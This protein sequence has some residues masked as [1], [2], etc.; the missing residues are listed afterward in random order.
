MRRRHYESLT[1][2][3]LQDFVF[4]ACEG[5][6]DTHG[7][8]HMQDVADISLEIFRKLGSPADIFIPVLL[9]SWLHDVADHKY[10]KKGKLKQ[11]V[12]VF[13]EKIVGEDVSLIM[14]TIDCISFS[15]ENAA[16]KSGNPLDFNKILG[17]KYALVRDIVSDADKTQAIGVEGINRCIKFTRHTYF[18]KNG[19]EIPLDELKENVKKHAEEKLLRLKDEFFRTEPGKEMTLELHEEMVKILSGL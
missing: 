10:D 14:I 2:K 6:D 3:A 7:F 1:E 8:T 11:K 17:K 15:K 12:R 16:M 4:E 19:F 18:E 5:R 13:V 9:V